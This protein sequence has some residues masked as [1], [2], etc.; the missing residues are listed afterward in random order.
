MICREG[1]FFMGGR[2]IGGR[3]WLTQLRFDAQ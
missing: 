3:A 1:D 2:F